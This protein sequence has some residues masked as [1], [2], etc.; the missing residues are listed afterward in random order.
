ME[1]VYGASV[2]YPHRYVMLA[3]ATVCDDLNYVMF[4]SK[5]A[6]T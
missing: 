5:H 4:M 6:A 1:S 3:P 2:S